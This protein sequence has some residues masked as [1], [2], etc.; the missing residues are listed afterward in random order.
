[1]ISLQLGEYPGSGLGDVIA[2]NETLYR[3][4][5]DRHVRPAGPANSSTGSAC[6]HAHSG[7]ETAL[8]R[9][10]RGVESLLVDLRIRWL[11]TVG[12]E[13]LR[14]VDRYAE[15]ARPEALGAG[16]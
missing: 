13:D 1:V 2:V 5:M 9:R 4:I 7:M 3:G 14:P 10:A 15:L 11:R 12:E 8:H 6:D 16:G